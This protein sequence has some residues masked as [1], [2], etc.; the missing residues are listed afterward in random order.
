MLNGWRRAGIAVAWTAG[1]LAFFEVCSFLALSVTEHRWMSWERVGEDRERALAVAGRVDPAMKLQDI[2]LPAFTTQNVVQPFLGYVLDSEFQ[3]KWRLQRGGPDGPEYGFSLVEPGLFHTRAAHQAIVGI[4]GGSVANEFAVRHPEFL[5]SF[6]RRLRPDLQRVILINLAI[7]GYKQPQQLMALAWVLSLGA[8]FDAVVN[9]DGFNEIALPPAENVR[10]GVNPFYPRSWDF[11]VA[12]FD[13]A[14]QVAAGEILALRHTRAGRAAAFG[15]APWRW[16]MTSSLLW[17]RL[18][19]SLAST[20]S[21]R[22]RELLVRKAELKTDYRVTGPRRAY[23][24]PGDMYRDLARYWKRCSEEMYA[25]ARG[26]HVVYIHALQ[27]NQY[28]PGSKAFNAAERATA[29]REDDGYGPSVRA[30]YPLLEAEGAGL[31]REGVRFLDLTG[32]FKDERGPIYID[33]CC[34]FNARGNELMAGEI[35]K[36][37]ARELP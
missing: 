8:Q 17:E 18:D 31:G 25:L 13:A 16:S 36:A 3:R 37:L 27:P 35:A 2:Q 30:A 32:L 12:T 24:D 4:T 33:D 29:F 11:Q 26:A 7:P 9:I 19:H 15:R 10:R 23:R 21:T 28:V 20:I 6:L 34:H 1:C 14:F 22:E 5:R